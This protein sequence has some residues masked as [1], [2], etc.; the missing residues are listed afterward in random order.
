[1]NKDRRYG[2]WTGAEIEH[3]LTGTSIP[4]RISVTTAN[5]PLVVPL[6]FAYRDQRLWFCSPQDSLLAR[7]LIA[8]SN[9][10]FDISTN[11]I[12]YMGV[13]GRG[14]YARVDA[15]GRE[16]LQQLLTRYLG[17]TDNELS[18]WLLSRAE[19]EAVLTLRISWMTSWD[20]TAR[21]QD[22]A[23]RPVAGEYPRE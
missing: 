15:G 2:T 14:R 7:S 20:F 11:D 10:A 17:D 12:P 8:D 3:F 4:M 16:Q 19:D 22:V 6:W 1:V 18:R 21:M 13:R 23:R 9:V 5:G